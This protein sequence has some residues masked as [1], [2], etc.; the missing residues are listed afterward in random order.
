MTQTHTPLGDMA[1]RITDA[2]G[3][4]DGQI[5]MGDIVHILGSRSHY[6]LLLAVSAAA[7]TPLSGIPG[8]S[9]VC[10]LLI[11]LIA[12]E[13]IFFRYRDV[14]VPDKLRHRSIDTQKVRGTIDRVR[15]FIDWI[16]RHTRK[17]FATIFTA[18]LI[19]VPLLIC[20]IS[21]ATM[22]FLEVIP[23][24]SSIVASGVLLISIGL[25]TRDGL[26]AALALIPYVAIVV[27]ISRFLS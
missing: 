21:G 1:D 25:V 2:D 5:A 24:T 13:R 3:N 23:F 6:A 12:G 14:F 8:V 17:R 22:P 15:P 27:L 16:D 26:F 9:A 20:L 4:S 7:A 18:P 19:Y 10:G 11:A